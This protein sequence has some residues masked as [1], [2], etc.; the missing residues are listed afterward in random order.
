MYFEIN[1][2]T[3][4]Q[5][6]WYEL[7]KKITIK[8]IAREAGVSVTTVSRVLNKTGRIGSKTREKIN[9]VIE[10]FGYHP[11]SAA[12]SMKTGRTRN[13]FFVVPDITNPFYASLAKELQLLSR[14]KN[15][16][17]TLYNT[18]ESLKE[19][20]RAIETACEVCAGGI[21]FASINESREVIDKLLEA[22]IPAVL[23]NSYLKCEFDTVHGEINAG[24]YLSTNFLIE[25]GHKIIGFAGA[26][27][28]T[29][30]G[31]S[32]KQGYITALQNAGLNVDEKLSF[33][34]GFSEDAG[35]KAGKYFS[36]LKKKPTAICC[37]ND[38]VA[39]GV[40][41]ALYEEG[42]V[43]PD[44]ISIVG[45]DDIIYS[46]ISRP[47]LT[48]VSNDSNVFARSAFSMLFER[49]ENTYEGEPREII[50]ERNLIIRESVST[51]KCN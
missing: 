34:M 2:K 24:T 43:V 51:N 37:A 9:K 26:P 50:V 21:V 46:R 13:I 45:M 8:D 7:S 4:Y 12:Q 40:L 10:E 35:Y 44:D 17:I 18:N 14:E 27:A 31:K 25:N 47:P 22:N 19:E 3:L 41:T 32:R 48:S 23:L 36:T 39:M 42:I 33:E 28:D 20:L 29:T 15:Y 49:I 11:N 5:K 30:V 6:R 38:I 1:E 16:N